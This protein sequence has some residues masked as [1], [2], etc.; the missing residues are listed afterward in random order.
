MGKRTRARA[1]KGSARAVDPVIAQADLTPE[2]RMRFV[3]E[4]K[5]VANPYG[6]VTQGGKLARAH[7]ACRRVPH[8]E[9]LHRMGVIDRTTFIALEW[10]ADQWAAANAGLFKS[11]LDTA[12]SGGGSAASHV[13]VAQAAMMARSNIKWARMFMSADLLPVFDGVME[14]G[15][16]FEQVG[17]RVY[18][19][20]STERARRKASE[21]FRIACAQLL[22][23]IAA[24]IGL[25]ECA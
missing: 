24:Q 3:H 17:V 1:N 6:E 5:A 15:E 22:I 7:V 23:G 14:L 9:T 8:F 16:T 20:L 10:Y 18:A 12:G 11:L 21:A 13:P 25:S 2:Q 19:A 4:A